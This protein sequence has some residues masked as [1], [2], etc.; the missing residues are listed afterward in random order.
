[1]NDFKPC[2]KDKYALIDF[3][4]HGTAARKYM[5]PD[6]LIGNHVDYPSFKEGDILDANATFDL[7]MRLICRLKNK[8]EKGDP[9]R[10]EDFTE[11]QLAQLKGEPGLGI[12]SIYQVQSSDQPG[13][14]NVWVIQFTDGTTKNLVINN[15][16]KGDPFR[17]E[18]FTEEQLASLK[19]E[20]GIQ[21]P[22]G[23]Q[24]IQGIQ[25][26][27]GIQGVQGEQGIQGETGVGIASMW[28]AKYSTVDGGENIWQA[29]LTDGRTF[30]FSVRNGHPIDITEADLSD[31]VYTKAEI[32]QMLQNIQQGD[33][34]IHRVMRQSEYDALQSYDDHTIYFITEGASTFP[35]TFPITLGGESTGFPAEF[36]ITL[37]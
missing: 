33:G 2:I 11:E 25:G 14:S 7:V 29:V 31:I 22:Q 24:G 1:M 16:L 9:F 34:Y 4:K 37:S 3:A 23:E 36:P 18:D 30:N 27:Q 13:G 20:Q 6:V 26:E 32:D 12:D 5:H 17:F 28:Q 35:A 21:G 8:G 15:G 10:F 19:G